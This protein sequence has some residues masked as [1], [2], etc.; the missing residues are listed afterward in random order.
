MPTKDELATL[1]SLFLA[2]HTYAT[3]IGV[4]APPPAPVPPPPVPVPPPPPP[5]PGTLRIG[6][7][8]GTSDWTQSP[9][10]DIVHNS[11]GFG[12]PSE[13]E[14]NFTM[15]RDADGWP[16]VAS[17]I[18][19]C[20][21]SQVVSVP[22][23]VYKGSYSGLGNMRVEAA[24]NA[25]VGNIVRSGNAVTFDLTCTGAPLTLILSFDAAVRDLRI[26]T[27]G[28]APGTLL[29]K[30]AADFWGRYST[31]R[32]MPMLEVNEWQERARP[33]TMWDRRRPAAKHHG[34]KS[35]E[36]TLDVVL[37]VADAPGSRMK[38]AWLNMPMRADENYIR[39]AALLTKARLPATMPIY[40]EFG[41]EIWE[42]SSGNMRVMHTAAHDPADRDFAYLPGVGE[43]D[44][45][46]QLWAV[47]HSRMAKIW[48]EV[49]GDRC[50]PV[51]A[52][53]ADNPW[54]TSEALRFMGEKWFTEV[55]GPLNSHTKALS[56][57]PYL[58]ADGAAMDAAP[59]AAAL[60]ALLRTSLG[61][62]AARCKSFTDLAARY[63]IAEVTC[64]EWGLHTH[65]SAN[66]AVKRAAHLDPAVEALVRDNAVELRRAGITAACYLGAGPQKHIVSDVNSLWGVT[67]G[68]GL[69]SYK[70][71]GLGI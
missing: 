30:E 23:G 47:R 16:T 44:R 6:G 68:Y 52:G 11:R 9:W 5:Q 15:P 33:E 60:L 63:N 62:V 27:P 50:K 24:G 38:E 46:T 12:L 35:W 10:A 3:T 17:R 28:Y 45:F 54:W 39:Q 43:W 7:N 51:L 56:L 61:T 20:A 14:E 59:D 57:A 26:L 13:Y 71:A 34:K 37:A 29:R 25:T 49:L 48:V 58:V 32:M 2:A 67:E 18:V 4:A 36:A 55:F 8:F 42:A 70:L 1:G 69:A 22:A 41:N 64:Y 19:V 40:I 53:Q 65:G 31:L 66:V 21:D